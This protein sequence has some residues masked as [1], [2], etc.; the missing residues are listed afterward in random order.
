MLY[1]IDLTKPLADI[2]GLRENFRQKTTSVHMNEP[3][4]RLDKQAEVIAVE[5][6]I[7]NLDGIRQQ[8][9]FYVD[10]GL[11]SLGKS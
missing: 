8:T 5:A 1:F 10:V 7:T 4:I 11:N 6:T 9:H 3:R 2:P